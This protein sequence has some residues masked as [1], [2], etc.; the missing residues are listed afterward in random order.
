MPGEAAGMKQI[1]Q[2]TQ[3]SG[4]ARSRHTSK[5]HGCA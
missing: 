5:D 4:T 3:L 2:V 1:I